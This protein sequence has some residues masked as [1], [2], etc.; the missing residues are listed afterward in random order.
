MAH[1][2]YTTVTDRI[3]ARL[4]KA[5]LTRV[6][7]AD[8]TVSRVGRFSADGILTVV[9]RIARQIAQQGLS[10]DD[11]DHADGHDALFAIAAAAPIPKSTYVP[12]QQQLTLM[13]DD[14]KHVVNAAAR[15]V[16]RQLRQA[17]R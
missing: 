6:T 7:A 4:A 17:Q 1:A 13:P 16:E 9:A 12:W 15:Q 8:M 2:D 10:P 5:A 14:W 11:L 3:A